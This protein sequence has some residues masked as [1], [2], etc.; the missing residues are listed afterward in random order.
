MLV[1]SFRILHLSDPHFGINFFGYGAKSPNTPA[2]CA[3][4]LAD[5]IERCLESNG[6]RN[7]ARA[8]R[9]RRQFDLLVIS[10]DLTCHGHPE[11]MRAAESFHREIQGG[12]GFQRRWWSARDVLVIPGNHDIT[13]G[14][15]PEGPAPQL[16]VALPPAEREELYRSTYFKLTRENLR[17]TRWLGLLKT[18]GDEKIAILGLDSCRIESWVKP[19]LG[20]VGFDQ[21]QALANA[22]VEEERKEPSKPWRRLAFLH[23]HLIAMSEVDA[24]AARS[25]VQQQPFGLMTYDAEQIL[26][27]LAHYRVDF[28]FHG[29]YHRPNLQTQPAHWLKSF[30]KL[31]PRCIRRERRRLRQSL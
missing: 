9:G 11:G 15:K 2:S 14:K 18:Y 7:E 22:A 28:A 21:L 20:F 23:H 29:H 30:R 6:M 3:K 17:D 16:V 24:A 1:P 4:A 19:G 13:F 31:R 26:E 5:D 25:L 10:G 27:G 8:K 12:D